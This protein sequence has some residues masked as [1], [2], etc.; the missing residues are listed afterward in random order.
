MQNLKMKPTIVIRLLVLFL[1]AVKCYKTFSSEGGLE[2]NPG[3]SESLLLCLDVKLSI[4]IPKNYIERSG[5]G[6]RRNG[7]LAQKV[8][9]PHTWDPPK[10]NMEQGVES[11]NK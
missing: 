11:K 3:V 10:E 5:V 9:G 2:L 8:T 7:L 1:P 6:S 4:V